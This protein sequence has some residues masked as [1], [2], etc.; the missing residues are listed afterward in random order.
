MPPDDSEMSRGGLCL[1]WPLPPY[2]P[3]PVCR[4][5]PVSEALWVNRVFRRS[6]LALLQRVAVANASAAAATPSFR[7]RASFVGRSR[8]HGRS[9]RGQPDVPPRGSLADATA[10]ACWRC[11]SGVSW[12]APVQPSLAALR[13][14]SPR[15]HTRGDC[16]NYI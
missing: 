1:G 13:R 3:L 8:E 10:A 6:F 12:L 7:S 14:R 11:G 16:Y 15:A 5:R 4:W 2:R 9:P